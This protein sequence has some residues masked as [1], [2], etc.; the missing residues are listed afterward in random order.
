MAYRYYIGAIKGG[1]VMKKAKYSANQIAEWF[2]YYNRMMMQE[3]D[4]DTISNLKLQKLLYYAQ[5]CYL[6]LRDTTLF[7][8]KIL[9]WKHG[10]AINEI[11]QKY[12]SYGSNGIRYIKTFNENIDDDTEN[13]LKQVYE[14]FGQYSAWGL[15]NMTHN[16]TP[17]IE[18][19]QS[20]EIKLDSIKN[21]FKD[22]YIS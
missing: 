11:Y 14:E 21:Y 8:E 15:R 4:A 17:W 7:D 20:S 10:P 5:G 13:I 22:T 18:T 12:K 9:A 16:E 3:A 1:N 19:V 2:L 6:A